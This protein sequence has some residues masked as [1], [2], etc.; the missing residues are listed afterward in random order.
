MANNTQSTLNLPPRSPTWSLNYEKCT[1]AEL[2]K[3][4]EDRTGTT[5]TG[6]QLQQ[7]QDHG[8]SQLIDQLR[9]MDREARFPRFMELVWIKEYNPTWHLT[10]DTD[11]KFSRCRYQ[12]FVSAY[13][14]PCSS[15]QRRDTSR[16]GVQRIILPSCARRKRSTRKRRRSCTSRTI[17]VPR[18]DTLSNRPRPVILV[19]SRFVLSGFTSLVEDTFSTTGRAPAPIHCSAPYSTTPPRRACCVW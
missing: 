11:F 1:T 6:E 15:H 16:K 7:V 18:L 4:I 14:R 17:F 5:L 9:Q 2:R 8:S 10:H 12:S 19:S 13:T 3:F